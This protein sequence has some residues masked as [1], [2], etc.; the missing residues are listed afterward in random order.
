MSSNPRGPKPKVTRLAD[1]VPVEVA[2]FVCKGLLKQTERL[3]NLTSRTHQAL[4]GDVREFPIYEPLLRLVG[5]AQRGQ[6][7]APMEIE[8]TL[9]TLAY[10]YYG[11]AA[12]DSSVEPLGDQSPRGRPAS[13]VALV[14]I[15]GRARL[16]IAAGA[17][18][19]YRGLAALAGVHP[20]R[21]HALCAGASHALTRAGRGTG[22]VTAASAR[23]WLQHQQIP[24]FDAVAP[25]PRSSTKSSKE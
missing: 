1:L 9:R 18:V 3:K 15:A 14:Y 6:L 24:G 7:C 17:H 23:A 5:Y 16:A 25:Q 21:I 10:G 4:D 20:S 8:S 13:D 19:D 12:F 2:T 11:S 22:A